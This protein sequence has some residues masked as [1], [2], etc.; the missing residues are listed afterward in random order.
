[1]EVATE[2]FKPPLQSFTVETEAYHKT[3]SQIKRYAKRELSSWAEHYARLLT[4]EARY[5]V[6]LSH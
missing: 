2:Y 4:T 3:L 1:V 6:S 5:S